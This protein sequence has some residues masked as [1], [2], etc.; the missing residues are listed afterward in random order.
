MGLTLLPERS[1]FI[2][3]SKRILILISS[4]IGIPPLEKVSSCFVNSI[5][6]CID[7]SDSSRYL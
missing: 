1:N 2:T 6:L 3:S 4:F 5:A 7:F